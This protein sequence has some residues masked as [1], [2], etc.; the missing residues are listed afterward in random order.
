MRTR[1]RAARVNQLENGRFGMN[2]LMMQKKMQ[3]DEIEIEMK[4]RLRLRLS[5]AAPHRAF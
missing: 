4:L 5:G 1:A 3:I 2:I